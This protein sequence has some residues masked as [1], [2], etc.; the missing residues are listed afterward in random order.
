MGCSQKAGKRQTTEEQEQGHSRKR[1]RRR[2]S[3]LLARNHRQFAAARQKRTKREET[4]QKTADR[5]FHKEI[6]MG[7]FS[8]LGIFPSIGKN[9][10]TKSDRRALFVPSTEGS[11]R[12]AHDTQCSSDERW[13]PPL[14]RQPSWQLGIPDIKDPLLCPPREARLGVCRLWPLAPDIADTGPIR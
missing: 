2:L 11:S 14:T 5:D 1:P 13:E 3:K 12:E 8:H 10:I 7:Y 6:V 4:G 9:T